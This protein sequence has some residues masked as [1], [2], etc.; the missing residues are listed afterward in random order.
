[1]VLEQ[2]IEALHSCTTLPYVHFKIRRRPL[3]CLPL[4]CS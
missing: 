3:D 4:F 2:I 1:V